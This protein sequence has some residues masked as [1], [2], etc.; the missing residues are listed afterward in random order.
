MSKEKDGWE[1]AATWAGMPEIVGGVGQRPALNLHHPSLELTHCAGPIGRVAGVPLHKQ[2]RLI[3]CPR[4]ILQHRLQDGPASR[5][6]S[7]A[8]M[9]TLVEHGCAGDPVR[10]QSLQSQHLGRCHQL[11]TF[12]LA[13][14]QL[15]LLP[16]V[17]GA[18]IADSDDP[19]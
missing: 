8:G 3:C 7:L 4:H 2:H 12:Q 10:V 16:P 17:F 9:V 11:E 6:S 5:S 18:G 15:A 13:L 19:T 1:V 14:G